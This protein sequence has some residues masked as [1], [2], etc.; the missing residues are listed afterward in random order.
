MDT[1]NLILTLTQ[2]CTTVILTLAQLSVTVILGCLGFRI[3][4]QTTQNSWL[5]TLGAISD[6]FWN[7]DDIS[8]IRCCITYP[9]AYQCLQIVLKRR[10]ALY[11]N[12]A[13]T[14]ELDEEEYRLLDKLDKF[15]HLQQRAIVSN[16]AFKEDNDLWK[17]LLFD[18][19]LRKCMEHVE[20]R[21]Y[22]ETFYKRLHEF[23]EKGGYTKSKPV[24][25]HIAETP[26]TLSLLEKQGAAQKEV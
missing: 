8:Y 6:K 14:A 5:Q 15:L 12:V 10:T 3:S 1:T 19:W 7:D 4:K 9:N 21:W 17:A 2:L 25:A 16:P 23:Y 20:L 24:Q 13:H 11:N 26:G 22:I 18:F